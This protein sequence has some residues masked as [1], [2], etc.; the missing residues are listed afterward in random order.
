MYCFQ[1][2]QSRFLQNRQ[3]WNAAAEPILQHV[4]GIKLVRMFDTR[5]GEAL[6]STLL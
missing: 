4:T 3:K 1:P 6:C 2:I 5:R